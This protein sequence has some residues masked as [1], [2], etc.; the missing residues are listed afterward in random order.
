MAWAPMV[1]G[2]APALGAAELPIN[3]I[4]C[5]GANVS[6]SENQM[7]SKRQALVNRL[8]EQKRMLE[9]KAEE[10]GTADGERWA[11]TASRHIRDFALLERL[12]KEFED[13]ESDWGE[14]LEREMEPLGLEGCIDH[15][16]EQD[17]DLHVWG[18]A[19]ADAALETWSELQQ[20]ID[21]AA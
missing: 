19:F 15:A 7:A 17:F 14:L 1:Q 3:Q 20:E 11:E 5:F 4:A 10:T 21:N 6:M 16:K 13:S 8:S 9:V 2:Q 12:D 18:K